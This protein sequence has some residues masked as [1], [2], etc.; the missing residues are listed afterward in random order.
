MEV[1][2]WGAKNR[3]VLLVFARVLPYV[4]GIGLEMK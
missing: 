2:F 4:P 1:S 3:E